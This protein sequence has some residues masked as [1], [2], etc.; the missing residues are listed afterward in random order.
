MQGRV[1]PQGNDGCTDLYKEFRVIM[2]KELTN[3]LELDNNKWIKR[4][5]ITNINSV[6]CHYRDYNAFSDCNISYPTER[7]QCQQQVITVGSARICPYCGESADDMSASCLSH[8]SCS[9]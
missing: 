1:Y 2:Q 7:P 6:G 4:N 9:I 3:I 8:S 5:S